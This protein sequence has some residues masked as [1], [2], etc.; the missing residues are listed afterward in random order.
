MKSC[1]IL[2]FISSIIDNMEVV[3]LSAVALGLINVGSGDSE[4][5]SVILQKLLE[6]TPFELADPHTRH[7]IQ[8]QQIDLGPK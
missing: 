1:I 4:I 7:D 8:V 3:S 5:S 6:L 2:S